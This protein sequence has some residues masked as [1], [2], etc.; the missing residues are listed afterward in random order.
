MK[1]ILK[2]LLTKLAFCKQDKREIIL[3][4]WNDAHAEIP[5]T[6]LPGLFEAQAARTPDAIAV[7]CGSRTVSYRELDEQASRLACYL[8]SRG[9]GPEQ[10]VGIALSRSEKVIISLLAVLK[11]GAAYLPIDAD[12]P[13]DRITFMLRDARPALLLTDAVTFNRLPPADMSLVI[14]DDDGTQAALA[15]AACRRGEHT[16]ELVPL[17]PAHPA[18]VIY[19]S[20]STGIPK[21]VVI[22]HHSVARLLAT[23]REMFGFGPCDTWSW[24]HSFAFDFSVWEMWGAL[25]HGGRL[26]VVPFEVSRSPEEFTRLLVKERVTVLCQTP[27]AFY[28]LIGTGTGDQNTARRLAVRW[29]ILGGEALDLAQLKDWYAHYPD[30]PVL[31]NMYGITETTV[32]V[33]HKLVESGVIT[34]LMGASPI[35]QG[36]PGWQTFVLDSRLQPVPP[37][38]MGELYI[39]GSGLARGYL[40]RPALTAERF[41][42]CPFG[43]SGRRMYRTG[44][45]ARWRQ[46]GSLEFCG[47]VDDQVKI[48]GFRIEPA[49]IEA[50]IRE[51]PG[52]AQVVV[53]PDKTTGGDRRLI[54]Y[55]I[56]A[57]QKWR[58]PDEFATDMRDYVRSRLPQFMVPSAFV[59]LNSFPLT[60]AGKLDRTALPAPEHSSSVTWRA[61]R[62]PQEELLCD[63]FAEVLGIPRVGLN[64]SFFDMG[65]HSLLAVRLISRIRSVLGIEIDIRDLFG[66][67]TVAGL[68]PLLSDGARS[69]RGPLTPMPRPDR[70]PLSFAQSRVWFLNRLQD[71][72]PTYNIPLIW[73]LYG[74]L[75]YEALRTALADIVGRHESLR[76]IF[77]EDEGTPYQLILGPA[78]ARPTVEVVPTAEAGLAS[79]MEHACQ[80]VFDLGSELPVR[81]WLF[82]L[83]TAEHVLVLVVHHIAADEWSMGPLLHDLS[84]AY[85]ARSKRREPVWL[86]LPVQYADYT[87]WQRKMLGRSGD[88][89]GI[90]SRQE[91]FWRARLATLP[92]EI[93]L[94]T[95]RPRPAVASYRGG[96]VRL[97]MGTGLRDR[98]RAL[99][100]LHNAT[101]FMVVHAGLVALLTRLGVGVDI[102]VGAPVA[103]RIDEVL[104][105]LVGFFLN[106]LVLR[107]DVSGDPSF[108][109]LLA[110]IREADLDAFAHQDVPFERVV[111]ILKPAREGP[112]NPLFQ[113]MLDVKHDDG[114]GLTLPGLRVAAESSSTGFAKFDLALFFTEQHEGQQ[115][116]AGMSGVIEYA[117][118]L[119]DKPTVEALGRHL[120]RL[121]EAVAAD[122][123]I[124]VSEV[125]ILGEDERDRILRQ[126]N[127]TTVQVPHA[128]GTVQERFAEQAWAT[129]ERIALCS[130]TEELT[131]SELD[132]RAN[133]LAHLLIDARVTIET[134]VAILL[135]RSLNLVV[136][137]LAV[138]KAGATYVPLHSGYPPAFMQ[139]VM[140]ESGAPLLL[141]DRRMSARLPDTTSEVLVV[142]DCDLSSTIIDAPD[143]TCH[144]DNLAYVMYT[145]GTTGIPKG[146]GVT[147]RDLLSLVFDRCWIKAGHRRVLF[148]APYAFDISNL[149]LWVPLL[150]GS[151]IVIAPPIPLDTSSLKNIIVKQNVSALHLTAGLF[152]AIAEEQPSALSGLRE[153]FTG[154]DVV[155]RSALCQVLDRN[156]GVS[157]RVLYGPTEVTLCASQYLIESQAD[158]P[159]AIGIGGPLDN[160]RLYVLDDR[161]APT[162]V[163]V[164]GELFI[165]G[166]GLARGYLGRPALTAERFVACPFGARGERMYR[167]GDLAR[168]RRDGTLEFAGRADEQVKIRGFRV[169]PGEIEAV[170]SQHSLVS[171]AVVIAEDEA[172]GNKRLIAYYISK[173]NTSLNS[174]ELRAYLSTRIPDYMVPSAFIPLD[175][176]PLTPNGKLNRKALPAPVYKH[177]TSD[178]EP[179]SPAEDVLCKLFAEVLGVKTVETADNFFELGGHSLLAIQLQGRID[180][181]FNIRIALRDILRARTIG[182]LAERYGIRK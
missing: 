150:L 40:R 130:G 89:G 106:T 154:G 126:W 47:R 11:A 95:D 151:E 46:D 167:T 163:G 26:V 54:A 124:R 85:E 173:N 21:G 155:A 67:P 33:T 13:S 148:H 9:V 93:S 24:F 177:A 180:A 86:P 10:V 168:W 152:N 75:D 134:P 44:D 123:D 94:P 116:P 2:S 65:G 146:V 132:R 159:A 78:E 1:I 147:H 101:L 45:L 137:I 96:W 138:L 36:I 162:A 32:H 129:P 156:R 83:T 111:E 175:A 87:L 169:E 84:A 91:D 7:T 114:D 22:T 128:E 99:G 62:S 153:V 8:L 74:A 56:P 165:A 71:P 97:E 37:G 28:Q 57:D 142:D 109:E 160:T 68:A 164:T 143:V 178:R 119:F 79:A 82:S 34:G 58:N 49:E 127:D 53:V 50:T 20:G 158:I 88:P 100:R 72:S 25:V 113:V 60:Q 76:T 103:G 18:Y 145:S 69:A 139:R 66:A 5:A 166:A 19:T 41:V 48:R 77:A 108:G 23:T 112:D 59:V 157:I 136:S 12:Y 14:L 149:E 30:R 73:R 105:G 38:V 172:S 29:V 176:F 179:G 107:A 121:L 171:D 125:D 104:D 115:S 42:A 131:Y 51:N 182:E 144:P 90:L 61:P 35:G 117:A 6:T 64:D 102:P 3:Q 161:L 122:P 110:R 52:A 63:L 27:S 140:E 120:V 55:I 98:L 181:V 141:T 4:Q 16:D 31:V 133:A 81:A 70:L 118:D 174:V 43:A 170:L 15:E 80:H 135:E 92:E 17:L 39:A